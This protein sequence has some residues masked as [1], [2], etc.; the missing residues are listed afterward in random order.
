MQVVVLR[1]EHAGSFSTGYVVRLEQLDGQ[2]F[3]GKAYLQCEFTAALQP[4]DRVCFQGTLQVLQ[5][6]ETMQQY[7]ADSC[8]WYIDLPT[9]EQIQSISAS[10]AWEHPALTIRLFAAQLQRSLSLRLQ[11]SM[12]REEGALCAALL[13]GDRISL[14]GQTALQFHR[15]GV[16]HLLALSGMHLSLI[17]AVFSWLL[18]R[19]RLPYRLRLPIL[20]AVAVGYLLLTG[21]AVSTTRAAIMLLMMQSAKLLGREADGLT[22]LSLFFT[23]CVV[24]EPYMLYDV[25]LWLTSLAVAVPVAIVP[26]LKQLRSKKETPT[27]RGIAVLGVFMTRKLFVPLGISALC[28]L[29][30]LLPMWLTF[31]EISYLSPIT[32]LIL[33]LPVAILLTLGVFWLL[34]MPFS[35]LPVAVFWQGYLAAGMERVADII[36]DIVSLTSSLPNPLISLRY[37]SL[38]FVMPVLGIVLVACLLTRMRRRYMALLLSLSL[39]LGVVSVAV[40]IRR[41]EDTLQCRY[42]TAGESEILWLADGEHNVVCDVTDGSYRPYAMLLQEGLD[43]GH[44]E[45]DTLILTHYHGKHVSMLERL[46]AQVRIAQL[47]LP[48][49]MNACPTNKAEEDEGIARKILSL[50]ERYGIDVVFYQ[51]ARSYTLD[52]SFV[53]VGLQYAVLQRSAHPALVLGLRHESGRMISFIGS[54]FAEHTL[55]DAFARDCL[56]ESEAVIFGEHGPLT[57]ETFSVERWSDTLQQV[58]VRQESAGEYLLTNASTQAAFANAEYVNVSKQEDGVTIFFA[59]SPVQDVILAY[60]PQEKREE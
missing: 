9:Q 30:L 5:G 10:S 35:T 56:A 19:F 32:S 46:S 14:D 34:L 51:P 47:Y 17:M 4:G 49:S 60:E 39:L 31:G 59:L 3:S 21:G 8:R 11:Q 52:D 28:T 41:T 2:K 50:A 42:I 57:K 18:I 7:L 27:R 24:S 29:I 16:S 48:L 44:T 26:A 37:A 1:T 58:I 6:M 36:L 45:I 38:K 40:E 12:G 53:L 55:T 23:I 43:A 33:T 15:S 20:A 25:A 54:A 22:S 13:L